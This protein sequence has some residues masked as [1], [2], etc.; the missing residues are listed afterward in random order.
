MAVPGAGHRAE[1]RVA[2]GH[3]AVAGGEAPGDTLVG[4]ERTHHPYLGAEG[5]VHHV[6][7]VARVGLHLC[8]GTITLQTARQK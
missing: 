2:C 3:P 8:T 5:D 1:C 6:I 7:I 4:P